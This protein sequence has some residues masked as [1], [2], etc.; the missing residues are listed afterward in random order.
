MEQ[1]RPCPSAREPP[2]NDPSPPRIGL[3]RLTGGTKPG[4]TRPPSI[5][6]FWQPICHAALFPIRRRFLSSRKATSL[7]DSVS[8]DLR[9]WGNGQAIASQPEPVAF[10]TRDDFR[11]LAHR[12]DALQNRPESV[13]VRIAQESMAG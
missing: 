10:G 6:D 2:T 8:D 1:G 12:N 11:I 5:V 3:E 13:H 7:R 9:K 4:K